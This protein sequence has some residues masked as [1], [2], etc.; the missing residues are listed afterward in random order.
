MLSENQTLRIHPAADEQG[1]VVSLESHYEGGATL[2][3]RNV[4]FPKNAYDK[5]FGKK[6]FMAVEAAII[7]LRKKT[8]NVE[9]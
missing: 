8:E 9:L 6:F 5:N 2:I 3:T 7:Y 4:R 1:V